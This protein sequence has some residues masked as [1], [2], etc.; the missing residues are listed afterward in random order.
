MVDKFVGCLIY[1][2]ALL[3]WV[4]MVQSCMGGSK[5]MSFTLQGHIFSVAGFSICKK[6]LSCSTWAI[7]YL[8]LH[9]Q[10]HLLACLFLKYTQSPTLKDGGFLSMIFW[11]VLNLFS[12]KV[13]FDIANANLC[14]SKFSIPESGSPKKCCMGSDSW[15]GGTFGSLPT[16]QEEWCFC[17]CQIWCYSVTGKDLIQILIQ[18]SGIFFTKLF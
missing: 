9:F 11:A 6:C 16:Y 17:S 8:G 15:C 10:S 13:F 18:V 2:S 14:V 4:S 5:I 3:N 12:S 1:F 7:L